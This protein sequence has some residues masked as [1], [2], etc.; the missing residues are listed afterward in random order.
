M[1]F[2]NPPLDNLVFDVSAEVSG[3]LP[4]E[5]HNSPLLQFVDLSF[6]EPGEGGSISIPEWSRPDLLL[7]AGAAMFHGVLDGRRTVVASFD[8]VDAGMTDTAAFPMFMVNAVEW[9]NPLR[10]LPDA[11]RVSVG[12]KAARAASSAG[13][14]TQSFGFQ[15][16]EPPKGS[17]RSMPL[18][19][20][21]STKRGFTSSRRLRTRERSASRNS[22]CTRRG[23]AIPRLTQKSCSARRRRSIRRA[24]KRGTSAPNCGRGSLS[25]RFWSWAGSGF[26]LTK[27][28][29]RAE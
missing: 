7:D 28:G 6:L 2:F 1:I 12:Q 29:Q 8:P 9:A 27:C 14:R 16:R 5:A 25:P 19:S 26:G 18:P 4:I 23:P 24:P 3:S 11:S 20:G 21:R 22:P 17:M 10:A 15:R 13:Y